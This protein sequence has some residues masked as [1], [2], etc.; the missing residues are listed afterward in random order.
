MDEATRAEMESRLGADFS[1]VRLH[2][3]A[4][5]KASAAEVGARA[6]TAGSHVVIGDGGGDK[7]TLAHELTHVIQQRQGP[8]AGSDNGSGLKVSDP[9][10][11]FERE[12]EANAVRAMSGASPVQRSA[13][14][15]GA[16]PAAVAPAG[17]PVVQRMWNG[18]PRRDWD[19]VHPTHGSGTSMQANLVAGQVP[20]DG[21]GVNPNTR[22]PWWRELQNVNRPNYDPNTAQ[23]FSDNMVQGHLLNHRIG[24][25]G[26]TMENLTP[27]TK[28][29][30]SFHYQ[31]AENTVINVALRRGNSVQYTV[32]PDYSQHPTGASMGAPAG[33]A[34]DIDANFA[35]HLAKT[36]NADVQVYDANGN[37]MYGENWVVRNGEG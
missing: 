2:D 3:D 22:P 14:P 32:T 8:V 4:A 15:S 26:N 30:N 18:Q 16:S 9:S 34:A 29:A 5:A 36:T 27:F 10:D 25:P 11:R 7:H 17:Q 21:S 20:N 19:P 24:G 33:V 35:Q 37:W 23:W 12:A 13:R 31:S 6:Y 28:T 1:D